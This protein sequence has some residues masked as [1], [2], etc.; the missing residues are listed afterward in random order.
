MRNYLFGPT[1]FQ[2]QRPEIASESADHLG[3]RG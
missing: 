2:P 1:Q 3:I